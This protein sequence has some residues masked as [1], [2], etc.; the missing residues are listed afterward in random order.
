MNLTVLIPTLDEADNLAELFPRLVAVL[1]RITPSSWEI[2]IVDGGSRDRTVV[3]A[4]E[5]GA[6]VVVQRLPGFGGAMHA[7]IDEA[8]GDYILTM[9]A[10]LSHEPNF[11]Y[12]LWANRHRADIIIASRYCRGGAAY[13]PWTRKLLSRSLNA[14]FSW[15]LALGVRDLSSGFRLYRTELLKQLELRGRNFEILEEILVRAHMEGRRIL[16]TPFTYFPRARGSSHARIATFGMDLLRTFVRMWKL[17][18]SIEAAD[19]DERAFYSPI[20]PQ[21]YW[22]RRRHEIITTFARA[23]NLIID[24][25]CGS[26]VVLQSLN[27]VVGVDVSLPKMRYMR[28]YGLPVVNGSVF[29]LPFADMAAD[30]VICSEVIEHIPM[31]AEVFMELNRVLRPGGLLILGTPD[32]GTWTWPA[33]EWLYGILIPGGYADEHISHYSAAGLRRLL[34]AMGYEVLDRRYILRGELII[35]ARRGE[36]PVERATIERALAEAS[37][38]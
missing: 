29:A 20:L 30:C 34:V 1:E 13:M 16:E 22:Q 8:K 31:D 11:V 12:K 21:R 23:S 33:I 2:I 14:L 7:G 27:R 26:S 9:D 28:R 3:V 24:V 35:A 18:N 10:D 5:H 32:Y 4:Q 19:Y 25:G 15:G 36:R 17:R 38:A 6:R 37:K